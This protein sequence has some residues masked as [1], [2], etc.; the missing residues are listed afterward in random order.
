MALKKR[1]QQVGSS[2]A[3]GSAVLDVQTDGNPVALLAC[4]EY[5]GA[6]QGLQVC[7]ER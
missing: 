7:T 4:P 2:L 1:P 3:F 5:I 6:C